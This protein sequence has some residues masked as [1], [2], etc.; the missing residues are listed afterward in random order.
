MLPDG[1]MEVWRELTSGAFVPSA[2][3]GTHAAPIV[4]PGAMA[5]ELRDVITHIATVEET[6][7]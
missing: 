4:N 7:A 1:A 3:E 2:I 5:A 6:H